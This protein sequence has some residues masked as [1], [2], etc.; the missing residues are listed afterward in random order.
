M[1][2]FK[3]TKLKA[4]DWYGWMFRFWR[5]CVSI[6]IADD[7]KPWERDG[8]KM[9]VFSQNENFWCFVVGRLSLK[10]RKKMVKS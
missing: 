1:K 2:L 8:V 4:P 10:V 5:F 3:V 6:A 7:G 9:K